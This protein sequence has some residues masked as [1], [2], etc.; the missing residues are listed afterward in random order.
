M[1]NLYYENEKFIGYDK[2]SSEDQ[3]FARGAVAPPAIKIGESVTIYELDNPN[4]SSSIKF[5]RA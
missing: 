2:L 4:S 3:L 1:I 5:T